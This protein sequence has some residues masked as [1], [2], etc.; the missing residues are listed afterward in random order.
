VGWLPVR[1][2]AAG[3]LCGLRKSRAKKSHPRTGWLAGCWRRTVQAGVVTRSMRV[4]GKASSALAAFCI[5]KLNWVR[6]KG[7]LMPS[8]S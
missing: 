8:D 6:V 7:A 3:G 5:T 2:A 1:S 4:S